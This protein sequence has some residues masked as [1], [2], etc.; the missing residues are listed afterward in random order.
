[1]SVYNNCPHACPVT[2]LV[3]SVFFSPWGAKESNDLHNMHKSA[4]NS[5]AKLN[6]ERTAS[7]K[8]NK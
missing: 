6:L 2:P 7:I 8:K 4:A 3:K 1:M 5:S